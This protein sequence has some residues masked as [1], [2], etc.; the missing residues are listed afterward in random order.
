LP[1]ATTSQLYGTLYTPLVGHVEVIV[2]AASRGLTIESVKLCS[3]APP[4]LVASIVKSYVPAT[5]E[6]ERVA[7]PS[8]LSVRVTPDG[9]PVCPEV[10]N[11]E[12][13]GMGEP[14]VVTPKVKGLFIGVTS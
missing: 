10:V 2:G 12:M 9:S 4:G 6:P 11:A 8:P 13:V 1:V 7:E 5:D 14:D 3:V